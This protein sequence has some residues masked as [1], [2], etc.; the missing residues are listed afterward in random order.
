MRKFVIFMMALGTALLLSGC[1]YPQ[2]EYLS[3]TQHDE[4]YDIDESNNALVV[5]NFMGLKNAI[6]S[7]VE[8]HDTYGI[9]R[10][11]N[12]ADGDVPA[13]LETAIYDVC[14]N[15]PM[16]VYAV[17]YMTHDCSMITSYY[18]I[19]IYT[20]FK[21]TAEE[22]A[23]VI[24]LGG[25]SGLRSPMTEALSE[26][27]DTFVVRVSAYT[28]IDYYTLALECYRNAP[29]GIVCIPQITASVYPNNGAQRV[30]EFKLD[31]GIDMQERKERQRVVKGAL[32]VLTQLLRTERVSVP[33][34]ICTELGR[35]VAD[36]TQTDEALLYD[37]LC[38]TTYSDESL[39][40]AF[41]QLCKLANMD[42]Q[43][44]WGLKNGKSYC[45]N[46]VVLDN[47][48][49]HLDTAAAVHGGSSVLCL[50]NDMIGYDW[51]K[52]TYPSCNGEPVRE[53]DPLEI[54]RNMQSGNAN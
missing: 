24:R 16:G 7:F 45:W 21:K 9:I 14:R 51:D 50:D 29:V 30:I 32:E 20:T 4:Q 8:K 49:Y 33:A 23:S 15:D 39:V 1:S 52:N 27:K 22:V 19:H 42:S 3:I 43:V 5:D 53:V 26:T 37:L 35:I 36:K 12:Y 25:M 13:D 10:V 48:W 6:A 31:Y 54:L 18:E 11:Y 2:T 46:L 38:G 40:L 17:D 41:E 28:P 34:R 47:V 44:I